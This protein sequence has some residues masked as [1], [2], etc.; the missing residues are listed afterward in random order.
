MIVIAL[1]LPSCR[2]V[3]SCQIILD[4]KQR[5]PESVLF[6]A[7]SKWILAD[8]SR[9]DLVRGGGRADVLPRLRRRNAPCL[10]V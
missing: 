1:C 3:P 8:N 9:V 5:Q 10:L 7:V 2:A 6:K 4:N